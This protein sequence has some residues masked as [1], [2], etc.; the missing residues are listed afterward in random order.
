[1]RHS[2]RVSYA[3]LLFTSLLLPVI[4]PAACAAG[5]DNNIEWNGIS[6]VSWQDRRPLCPV[7]NGGFAVRFQAYRTDLTSA[8]IFL[9]DG[10][11]TS[12]IA[13]SVAGQRG[14][15]DIWQAQIPP[16]LSDTIS[17][18]IEMTD[19]TD[20]DYLSVSG[21]LEGVPSDGGWVLDFS[22][23]SHAPV[24]ATL[25]AGGAV[26]RV[27]A[28]GASQCYARG[29][30]N[31]WDLSV[32]M[33]RVGEDFI[34]FAPGAAAGDEYKYYFN[35]GGIW[36]SDARSRAFNAGNYN[37]SVIEDPFGYEWGAVDFA[38]PPIDEA[39]VYQLHVGQVAGRN[40]PYGAAPH[41]SR[42]ID[43]AARAGHLAEL[44][45]NAVMIN[46]VT[47]FPGDLS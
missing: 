20:T 28:P 17:Y 47:E 33:A 31:G 44:G 18:W 12:W 39:I 43:V 38:I 10:G 22:T 24:G 32:P 3:F 14:A 19:G 7:M 8:R 37:N 46:P 5:N 25:C 1:M 42:Y 23:L 35:P 6:H 29:D 9:A 41:P 4:P 11:S 27:W 34:A 30:F 36:K 40:E 45:V 2:S 26:F 13:A 15:Y 21:M 16:T